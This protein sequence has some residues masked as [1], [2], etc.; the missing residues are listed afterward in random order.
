VEVDLSLVSYLD[1]SGLTT[2]VTARDR[3]AAEGVLFVLRS[4]SR[5]ATTALLAAGLD[6]AFA[7]SGEP[8]PAGAGRTPS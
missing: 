8:E 2:L 5:V 3:L 6:R 4:P 7:R 1:S